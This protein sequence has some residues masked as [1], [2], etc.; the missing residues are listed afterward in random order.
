VGQKLIDEIKGRL[1]T[2]GLGDGPISGRPPLRGYPRRPGEGSPLTG[3]FGFESNLLGRHNIYNLL[4]AARGALAWGSTWR[5]RL[6]DQPAHRR[7]GEARAVEGTEDIS[8]LIDYAIPTMRLPMSFQRWRAGERP[9]DHGLRCGG[10]RDRKSGPKWPRAAARS[11]KLSSPRT[12]PVPR[13]G[14]Y[15]R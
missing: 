3:S 13:T 15:H 10:D 14:G 8:V 1:M 12:T 9:P 4:A 2:Y 6:G 5:R 7:T 11:Q